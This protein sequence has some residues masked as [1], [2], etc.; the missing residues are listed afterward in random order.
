[1]VSSMATR[2]LLLVP[3]GEPSPSTPLTV[4]DVRGRLQPLVE[5]S[6]RPVA[7][8]DL[9]GA[10][11]TH[12]AAAMVETLL[13]HAAEAGSLSDIQSV[14]LA[15]IISAPASSAADAAARNDALNAFTVLVDA[16]SQWVPNF[17]ALDVSDNHLEA[18]GASRVVD[19]LSGRGP[20]LHDGLFCRC[21]LDA[22]AGRLL[23]PTLMP[24]SS[25]P[26]WSITP[27]RVLRLD[28]NPLGDAGAADVA[29]LVAR[30]PSLLELSVS[31]CGFSARGVS[32]IATGMRKAPVKRLT[33]LSLSH[34]DLGGGGRVGEATN[35][36][37]DD[38]PLSAGLMDQCLAE[39]LSENPDLRTLDLSHMQLGRQPAA[40]AEMLSTIGT[41]C[42]AL[43][44]FNVAANRL[45][46]SMGQAL[47]AAVSTQPQLSAL[48][49]AHNPRLGSAGVAAL[50][51][52][53]TA[54][55][56]NRLQ[57][58]DLADTGCG[59]LGALAAAAAASRLPAILSLS[60]DYG[61]V[62]APL[63]LAIEAAVSTV[64]LEFNTLAGGSQWVGVEDL[65]RERGATD[66]EVTRV[67][68]ALTDVDLSF[69]LDADGSGDGPA[70]GSTDDGA[71]EAT[72]STPGAADGTPD[73]RVDRG[74]RRLS[75]AN[76]VG[77][78]A[79]AIDSM[80]AALA[81]S[82]AQPT[83]P[84]QRGGPYK[85]PAAA[86]D[87]PTASDHGDALPASAGGA[88][89][90]VL[91]RSTPAPLASIG[92]GVRDGRS[93]G[94][95]EDTAV[96]G[97]PKTGV[98][99]AL[100]VTGVDPSDSRTRLTDISRRVRGRLGAAT[101][102]SVLGEASATATGAATPLLP[103]T[104]APPSALSLVDGRS[105]ATAALLAD[106]AGPS[107][108]P[109][110]SAEVQQQCCRQASQSLA[111]AGPAP[112]AANG[113]ANKNMG[114]ERQALLASTGGADPGFG[115]RATDGAAQSAGAVAQAADAAARAAVAVTPVANAAAQAG[116]GVAPVAD[117]VAPARGSRDVKAQ[118]VAVS[119]AD[120]TDDQSRR[121]VAPLGAAWDAPPATAVPDVP[122]EEIKTGMALTCFS[123]TIALAGFLLL[124]MMWINHVIWDK[125]VFIDKHL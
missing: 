72:R 97:V 74:R 16:V 111:P 34:N 3:E 32:A 33:S 98:E 121:R 13:A 36:S 26:S 70:G 5:G 123:A 20:S 100:L 66:E 27:L 93:G 37:D 35:D 48:V 46:S 102:P 78:R 22:A 120:T 96:D 110:V 94:V 71:T 57:T 112:K 12:D 62:A 69:L 106:A 116:D 50:M 117:A 77:A 39:A 87:T 92:P 10:A 75:G 119:T 4:S 73:G 82:P 52:N 79:S 53:L 2:S 40:C 23:L 9:G 122:P 17:L 56:H 60:L 65:R 103:R 45:P 31:G 115:F 109:P 6:R 1:M 28:G 18:T 107:K 86:F 88:S 63:A 105:A 19:L 24:S 64:S 90:F 95:D 14:S 67:T 11:Y 25:L 85:P 118:D 83:T 81:S 38:Q 76:G 104:G 58:V 108:A 61:V 41:C 80:A 99:P 8:L 30:S 114:D 89:P 47:G 113:R 15:R 42:R 49:A 124:V 68:T 125:R 29:A 84:Q 101:G 51:A 59:A 43:T 54:T 44:A 7:A 55:T 91:G 21:A